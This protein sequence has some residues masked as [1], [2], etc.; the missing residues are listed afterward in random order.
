MRREESI[1]A[2]LVSDRGRRRQLVRPDWLVL[3]LPLEAPAHAP[4]RLPGPQLDFTTDDLK[5][6]GL[7]VSMYVVLDIFYFFQ[8]IKYVS[9]Q[10]RI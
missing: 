3:V 1:P 9:K 4:V 6:H 7:R 10:I 5:D 2:R 8:K